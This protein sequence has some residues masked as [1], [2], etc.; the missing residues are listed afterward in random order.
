MGFPT[1][2]YSKVSVCNAGDPDSILGSERSP[3]EGNGYLSSI[4][5][6]RIPWGH[7]RSDTTEQLMLYFHFL[8][9]NYKC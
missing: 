4:L 9:T 8:L 6:W 5:A 3:V 2:S 7:K 1:G